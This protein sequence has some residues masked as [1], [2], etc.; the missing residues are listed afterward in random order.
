LLT[1]SFLLVL[2]SKKNNSIWSGKIN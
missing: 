2:S 1:V